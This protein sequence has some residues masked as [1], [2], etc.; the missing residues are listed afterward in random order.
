MQVCEFI[1]R[2]ERT[3]TLQDLFDLLVKAAADVGFDQVAYG[4]LTY[5][6]A[7]LVTS[8]Q[9]PA[10]ALNYPADWQERYF[11]RR[12]HEVDPVV[13]HARHIPRPFAWVQLAARFE[14]SRKQ[15]L[16]LDEAR[17]AGLKNGASVALHGPWGRVA[18]MSFAS[19]FA[20]ADPMPHLNYFNLLASQFHV[21]FDARAQ[22]LRGR[23][24]ECVHLSQREKDC[25]R[26]TAQGKSSWDIGM[27]LGI[28]E[29]TVTFHAKNA[30]RKLGTASRTVAV[31]RA[32]R[33]DLIDLPYDMNDAAPSTG[34]E[35]SAP[36]AGPG[37]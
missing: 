36:A 18:V 10:V 34:R 22:K 25:L 24:A 37:L 5:R 23:V 14:L 28:S 15:R 11:D 26:W 19:R 1:D 7:P 12:Y 3:S 17:D 9:P 8:H 30:M 33:L 6:E 32:I 31:L 16:V 21:T 35:F 20:D 2:S 13:I 4:A 27:I 29:N